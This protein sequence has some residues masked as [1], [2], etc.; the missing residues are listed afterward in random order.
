[1]KILYIEL[2]ENIAMEKPYLHENILLV[3]F[4]C[5]ILVAFLLRNSANLS[6]H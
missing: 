4:D 1:M 3:T 5:N 6:V 2:R